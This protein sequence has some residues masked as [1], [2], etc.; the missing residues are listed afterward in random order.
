MYLY[1]QSVSTK[2]GKSVEKPGTSNDAFNAYSSELGHLSYFPRAQSRNWRI[3]SVCFLGC[4]VEDLHAQTARQTTLSLFGGGEQEQKHSGLLAPP[5]H[6][7]THKHT[8][9]RDGQEH[10]GVI[11]IRLPK[12]EMGGG[13]GGWKA[14]LSGGKRKRNSFLL[15]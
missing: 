7:H 12:G 13:R 8:M 15:A 10:I 3:E 14:L 5:T 6:T 2:K 1:N 11:A 4:P 9:C